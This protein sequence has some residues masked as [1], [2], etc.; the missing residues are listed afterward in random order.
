[1]TSS[2]NPPSSEDQPARHSEQVYLAVQG[3]SLEPRIDEVSTSWQ[4]SAQQ[5]RVDPDSREVPRILT[6]PRK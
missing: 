5:Y 1:M 3:K 6:S 4:R 2:L